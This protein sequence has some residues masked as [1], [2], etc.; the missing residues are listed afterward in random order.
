MTIENKRIPKVLIVGP[1]PPP[2]GGMANFIHNLESSN[3][4]DSYEIHGF[5]TDY[6]RF[7]KRFRPL[8]LIWLPFM[9]L[10]YYYVLRTLN[11]DIVHVNTPSFNS[12]YKHSLFVTMA[13]SQSLPVVLHIH[14]GKFKD[15]YDG[16]NESGKANISRRLRKADRLI[17]LSES[18]REFFR[19]LCPDEIIRVVENGIPLDVFAPS[20]NLKNR[21]GLN[22]IFVGEVRSAKG[23]DE[24]LDAFSQ[25]IK[26]RT[27]WKLTIV[28]SG[29]IDK[30]RKIVDESGISLNVQ[31]AGEKTGRDLTKLYSESDIFVFPSH[32]EGMPLVVLEAMA[33]KLAIIASS[34]GSIPEILDKAGGILIPPKDSNALEN[35]IE[36]LIGNVDK[37]NSMGGIN[38]KTI[39]NRF[40]FDRVS[41]QIG[42]IYEELTTPSKTLKNG[43]SPE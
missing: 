23:M 33:M 9:Y 27:D 39:E 24:L 40:S 8:T 11:P 34:V 37:I 3:L 10:Q 32:S 2:P 31:F 29:Q 30:Y 5:D 4:R 17:V 43:D 42:K 18:W 14:G 35:A 38:K 13:K 41:E 7:L 25:L 20:E 15:F 12:F 1:H 22:F 36:S 6:P 28:G 21:K 16:S 26:K 19:T